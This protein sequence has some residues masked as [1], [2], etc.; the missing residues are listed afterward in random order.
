MSKECSA[1]ALKNA[2]PGKYRFGGRLLKMG[3]ERDTLEGE[4]PHRQ[5]GSAAVQSR[6]LGAR[7]ADARVDWPGIGAYPGSANPTTRGGRS[8]LN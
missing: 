8:H 5:R 3:R 7:V 6:S 1:P 4:V 2:R